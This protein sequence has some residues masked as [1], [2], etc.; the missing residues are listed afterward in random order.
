[1]NKP[2]PEP[3]SP[4]AVATYYDTKTASILM[5][6]GPGPRVHFHIGL[7]QQGA[8]ATTTTMKQLK[9]NLVDSQ[10]AMVR[11]AAKVWEAPATLSGEV[12]DA[13]CGLGG[14][15]LYWAQE[16]RARVTAVTIAAE[17]IPLISRFAAQ[18]GLTERVRPLLADVCDVPLDRQYTG[19]VAMES[20]CYFPRVRWFD[21]L[22]RLVAPGGYVC[23]EDTFLGRREWQQPFDHYWKTRVAPVAEYVAAAQAA[24]FALDRNEDVTDSTTEFWIQ[25]AA[26]IEAA[27]STGVHAPDE[28]KRLLQSHRWHGNFF[29][30]WRDHGI[31]VRLLRF[32]HRQTGIIVPPRA[33]APVPGPAGPRPGG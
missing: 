31:E 18:G 17:H 25:S 21:H 32:K 9:Q 12:L 19:V 24:G 3:M 2:A 1:M 7:F 22:S 20:A 10:E 33:T 30:A 28:E 26:W 29:R 23:I 27:L 11:Y 13:G 15:A 14:G 6:Y 8:L 5:K 4:E 16:H